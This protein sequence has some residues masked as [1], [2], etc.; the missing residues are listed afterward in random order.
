MAAR[1]V[2]MAALDVGRAL[3]A[4]SQESW[5]E[6]GALVDGDTSRYPQRDRQVL[7]ATQA[8]DRFQFPANLSKEQIDIAFESSGLVQK[9]CTILPDD[10]LKQGFEVHAE[11][12]RREP[13]IVSAFDAMQIASK[14]REAAVAARRTGDGYVFVGDGTDPASPLSEEGIRLDTV[15]GELGVR[16]S[17]FDAFQVYPDPDMVDLTLSSPTYGEPLEY[18]MVPDRITDPVARIHPSRLVRISH[19]PVPVKGQK[20]LNDDEPIQGK[21]RTYASNGVIQTNFELLLQA[22]QDIK[23]LRALLR[24]ASVTH[25]KAGDDLVSATSDGGLL[26]MFQAMRLQA[27]NF[28]AAAVPEGVEITETQVANLAGAVETARATLAR[29][30]ADLDIPLIRLLGEQASGLNASTES[31]LRQWQPM[32]EA[33][34]R[35]L[36]PHLMRLLEIAAAVR[37]TNFRRAAV[38]IEWPKFMPLDDDQ[39]SQLRARDVATIGARI[40]GLEALAS[41]QPSDEPDEQRMD[42]EGNPVM[43]EITG[44]PMMIAAEKPPIVTPEEIEELKQQLLGNVP[45]R[46][47]YDQV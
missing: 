35:S 6:P 29:L 14:L 9:C 31:G 36:E 47:A 7:G 15:N 26:A 38:V 28:H 41:M 18:L 3:M 12:V 16:L 46:D 1:D 27:S 37:R 42:D 40:D 25:Y 21:K 23:D 8:A 10:A 5:T 30:G 11:G 45:I 13:N 19:Q 22:Q 43:N 2:Y 39:R 17:V 32:V 44:E 20:H 33:Y 34:Q 4:R 24:K